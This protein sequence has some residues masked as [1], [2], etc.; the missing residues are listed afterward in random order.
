MAATVAG[1]VAPIWR[2]REH[3]PADPSLGQFNRACSP[4]ST[5]AGALRRRAA[6]VPAGSDT[7]ALHSIPGRNCELRSMVSPAIMKTPLPV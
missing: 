4:A 2:G 3:R 7:E 6:N 1:G 5:A